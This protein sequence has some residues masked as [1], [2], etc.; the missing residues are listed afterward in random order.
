M[1]PDSLLRS[2]SLSNLAIDGVTRAVGVISGCPRSG[3]GQ[4]GPLADGLSETPRISAA[5]VDPG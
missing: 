1:L 4:P 3:V 2:A 5:G